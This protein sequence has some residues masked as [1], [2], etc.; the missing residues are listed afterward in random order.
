MHVLFFLFGYGVR[1]LYLA[2]DHLPYADGAPFHWLCLRLSL[3]HPGHSV[4]DV[5][6]RMG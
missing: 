1:I 5:H 2:D 3:V 4:V 6:W